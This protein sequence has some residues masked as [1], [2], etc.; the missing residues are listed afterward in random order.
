MRGPSLAG[1]RKRHAAAAF[2][3]AL[4]L[5]RPE[6]CAAEAAPESTTL[7]RTDR[8]L[9]GY[10]A[11]AMV[12]PESG[13]EWADTW[14]TGTTA[15]VQLAVAEAALRVHADDYESGHE[16]NSATRA[17]CIEVFGASAPR[18]L[19]RRLEDRTP[20]MRRRCRANL[21]RVRL[22][23]DAIRLVDERHAEATGGY[24]SRTHAWSDHHYWLERRRQGWV[25]VADQL[26]LRP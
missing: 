19:L 23:I 6:P 9:L 21:G 13:A 14:A 15:E 26:G 12:W 11:S 16:T 8:E 22:W 7:T 18:A 4:A 10:D 17:H 3:L 25:V 1:H 2:V 5:A 24:E 20:R